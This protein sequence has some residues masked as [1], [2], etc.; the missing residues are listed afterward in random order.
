MIRTYKFVYATWQGYMYFI[1]GRRILTIIETGCHKN[2]NPTIYA[3]SMSLEK[4]SSQV[5]D[6]TFRMTII[7]QS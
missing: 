3:Y 7:L 2:I 4:K 1:D 6:F 5:N